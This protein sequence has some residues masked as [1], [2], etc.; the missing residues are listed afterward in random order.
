MNA[1]RKSEALEAAKA[2]AIE[3]RNEFA[4]LGMGMHVQ[5]CNAFIAEC[6]EKLAKLRS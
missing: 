6:N 1:T 4:R 5:A 3:A 2:D